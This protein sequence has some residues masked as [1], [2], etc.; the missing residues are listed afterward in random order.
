MFYVL[1]LQ[2]GAHNPLQSKEPKHSKNKLV[3]THMSTVNT[4]YM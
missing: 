1:F 4:Y 3:Y 2:V